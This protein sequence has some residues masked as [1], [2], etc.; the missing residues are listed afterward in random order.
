MR[1]TLLAC[2]KI[3]EAIQGGNTGFRLELIANVDITNLDPVNHTFDYIVSDIV[4]PM[5]EY[6]NTEEAMDIFLN[7]QCF[8][9]R[10]FPG[11]LTQVPM[12]CQSILS[13]LK[14]VHQHEGGKGLNIVYSEGVAL[15]ERLASFAFDGDMSRIPARMFNYLGILDGIKN[16]GFP[17]IDEGKFDIEFSPV[18]ANWP[19]YKP[20]ETD[21]VPNLMHAAA[22]SFHY[23]ENVGKARLF[24]ASVDSWD[25]TGGIRTR[26][27]VS[28]AMNTILGTTYV[29]DTKEFV[30]AQIH[31]AINDE[32]LRRDRALLKDENVHGNRDALRADIEMKKRALADWT[33]EVNPFGQ[34]YK[35]MLQ[36]VLGAAS[37]ADLPAITLKDWMDRLYKTLYP[38]V[39]DDRWPGDRALVPEVRTVM[40]HKGAT[41]P[42]MLRALIDTLPN[43][44]QLGRDELVRMMRQEVKAA[45]ITVIPGKTNKVMTG[46][47][48]CSFLDSALLHTE[49]RISI[50]GTLGVQFPLQ[51]LPEIIQYGVDVMEELM[52][53]AGCD[54]YA[55]M[56]VDYMDHYRLDNPAVRVLI[57]LLLVW[58]K[59]TPAPTCDTSSKKVNKGIIRQT[60]NTE[61]RWRWAGV[62]FI[63][64]LWYIYPSIATYRIKSQVNDRFFGQHKVNTR[65]LVD[66]GFVKPKKGDERPSY[67]LKEVEL[68]PLADYLSKASIWE[69]SLKA[70]NVSGVVDEILGKELRNKVCGG[71]GGVI[72]A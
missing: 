54:K 55:D 44:M 64:G 39:E 62:F 53:A 24:E 71:E 25:G 67:Q 68:L 18:G 56:L 33:K 12:M 7:I 59:L 61:E 43:H 69:R 28:Q 34:P 17:W 38:G 5:I 31:R 14:W 36:Q 13:S 72:D 70:G 66:C 9:K 32:R 47:R 6:W 45:K 21:G 46:K 35:D 65:W 37:A 50:R 22:L 48:I 63:K 19:R 2:R 42:A 26:H 3:K 58:G 52:R 4:R 1:P 29:T 40:Y 51:K 15:I 20:N 41:W 16:R 10:D 30:K 57:I 49:L 23:G 11:C 60:T 8:D 27:D